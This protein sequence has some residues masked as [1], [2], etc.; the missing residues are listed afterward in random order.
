MSATTDR[1]GSVRV[2]DGQRDAAEL[3]R[4]AWIDLREGFRMRELWLFLGWRDVRK[5]YSRSILGPFW[6]T[7]S[8]GAM[9]GG[10]G[11]L[12]S[13]ILNQNMGDYLPFLAIGFIMWGLISGLVLQSCNI[14][15]NAASSIRQVRMPTSVYVYQFV[16]QQIITFLHNMVIFLIVALIFGI[17][18]GWT[19]LLFIPAFAIICLNGV[20]A[21]MVLGPLCARFRD[22]PMI[23]AS[24]VQ[25][26]FF[27]TPIIWSADMVPQRAFYVDLN[28]FFHLIEIVRD[29]LLGGTASAV[30]WIV[31]ILGTA[32][33]G[34]FAFLFYARYRLRIPY[35][36]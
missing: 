2:F 30:N 6:L 10:L 34:A 16:W 11:L 12:Y 35:W 32:V 19:G 25:I 33:F 7:L 31:S 8:M 9:V 5:H 21:G 36:A 29:P 26:F 17:H 22:I 23:I 20:F 27:L 4:D 24:A 18:P 1:S 13:Q 28:P 14:Y 3:R 15:S